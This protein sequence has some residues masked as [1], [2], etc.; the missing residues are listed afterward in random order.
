MKTFELVLGGHPDK[1][2]D[3]IAEALK[4]KVDG[5]SAIEVAWFNDTI[6]VGGEVGK[7]LDN[8][9]VIRTVKE[10]LE[11]LSYD[12]SKVVILNF[13]QEQSKEIADIVKDNGAGDNGIF[14]A[15]YHYYWSNIIRQLKA[16]AKQ[17][18]KTAVLHRYKTDGKFI[19]EFDEQALLVK[20][21]LN[22][23]SDEKQTKQEKKW[24]KNYLISMLDLTFNKDYLLYINPN[25][26]WF[27]CGGFADSGLT[28]RKLA[29]DN[30]CGLFHQGGG[31]FFGK[32][33]SKADYSIPLY[34]QHKAKLYA[35]DN[36]LDSVEL[37]AYTIIGDEWVTIY[38]QDNKFI[39]QV[40]FSEIME[41][42]KNNPMEWTGL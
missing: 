19:A 18:T 14:F 29:C 5:K 42:A 17:L 3:I 25:G 41:F 6:I 39:D 40:E 16:I 10:V 11:S 22:I 1:V 15:G 36:G 37:K 2:C 33:V 8:Q 28:G 27:K 24:F 20:F 31:A 38:T 30:S 7:L 23:A 9:L 32:D 4:S 26:D 12:P 21:T 35:L 13:L 34:L